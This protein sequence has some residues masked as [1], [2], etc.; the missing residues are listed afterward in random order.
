[1]SALTLAVQKGRSPFVSCLFRVPWF[2]LAVYP[3]VVWTREGPLEVER[4]SGCLQSQN[5]L[6]ETPA[7]KINCESFENRTGLAQKQNNNNKIKQITDTNLIRGNMQP[8]PSAGKRAN[9]A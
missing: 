4:N 9:R 5:L 6:L 1:M 2:S 7:E 3:L 8:D